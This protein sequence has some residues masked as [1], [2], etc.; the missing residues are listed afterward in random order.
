MHAKIL[1]TL[2]LFCTRTGI[3]DTV[4]ALR[5]SYVVRSI[6]LFRAFEEPI[7][8]NKDA[9]DHDRTIKLNTFP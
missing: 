1:I 6:N 2:F 9:F 8:K 7:I 5:T 4:P 3:E